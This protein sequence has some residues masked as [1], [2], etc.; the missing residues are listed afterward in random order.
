MNVCAYGCSDV[1]SGNFLVEAEISLPTKRRQNINKLHTGKQ[2]LNISFCTGLK[3]YLE[4]RPVS[5]DIN[6][7][8]EETEYVINKTLNE[9]IG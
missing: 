8:W 5:S 1:H 7:Q 9:A 2:V 4:E 3:S 6:L